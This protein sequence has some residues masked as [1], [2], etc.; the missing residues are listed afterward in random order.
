MRR[1]YTVD[2]VKSWWEVDGG[3][4]LK[5]RYGGAFGE[6]ALQ[7]R[8]MAEWADEALKKG[9]IDAIWVSPFPGWMFNVLP[10]AQQLRMTVPRSI[11]ALLDPA[12]IQS[13][14]AAEFDETYAG[15]NK[16]MLLRLIR[17]VPDIVATKHGYIEAAMNSQDLEVQIKD[18]STNLSFNLVLVAGAQVRPPFADMAADATVGTPACARA[19]AVDM[20]TVDIEAPPGIL[21]GLPTDNDVAR[22]AITAGADRY[23]FDGF[24]GAGGFGRVYKF[25]KADGKQSLAMKVVL[26][27]NRR[28][29]ATTLDND[30]LPAELP[31]KV[32]RTAHFKGGRI[33]VMEMG[34][35][36]PRM[37]EPTAQVVA[38]YAA[39]C[40]DVMLCFIDR[41][42][43]CPDWKLS[44]VTAFTRPCGESGKEPVFRV[45]DVDGITKPALDR[46]NWSATFSCLYVPGNHRAARAGSSFRFDDHQKRVLAVRL[47]IQTAYAIELSKAILANGEYHEFLLTL[48]ARAPGSEQMLMGRDLTSVIAAL[49]PKPAYAAVVQLLQTITAI[50]IGDVGARVDTWLPL[51]GDGAAALVP[52]AEMRVESALREW[53]SAPD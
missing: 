37:M 31:C 29:L 19:P 21:N 13:W 40:R 24:I 51:M 42:L 18:N 35:T 11:D 2:P 27:P 12:L 48:G 26:P 5:T 43:V 50:R 4:D 47:Q 39:F 36:E 8:P 41:G 28:V 9:N 49:K 3:D 22:I 10:F 1:P 15:K 53:F 32:V 23:T 7:G 25:T 34:D 46:H 52:E 44:N 20:K 6:G 33:Q 38:A 30:H 16:T 14:L 17:E 45:I